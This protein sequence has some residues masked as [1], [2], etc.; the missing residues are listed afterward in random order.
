MGLRVRG[1]QLAVT[2]ESEASANSTT[3]PEDTTL[4][5]APWAIKPEGK[6]R[7]KVIF[8]CLSL[9]HVIVI[10]I[11]FAGTVIADSRPGEA[12]SASYG[13]ASLRSSGATDPL[14]FAISLVVVCVGCFA[15][16]RE[17]EKVLAAFL[18]AYGI[19]FILRL[20]NMQNFFW[21][22]PQFLS[23]LMSYS[24]SSKLSLAWFSL[25]EK[26]R[27]VELVSSDYHFAFHTFLIHSFDRTRHCRAV[28][29]LAFAWRS[30]PRCL[31]QNL[32]VHCRR[33]T[34]V[35]RKEQSILCFTPTKF[36]NCVS[37]NSKS[38]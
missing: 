6:R 19:D 30:F 11:D 28:S 38:S 4:V 5:R 20:A 16:I 26:C 12:L 23:L 2:D 22:L 8:L 34:R 9:I 18:I 15:A 31:E 3:L 13:T 27:L 35:L 1:N 21:L 29:C 7:T 33:A 25:E 14:A 32:N 36:I 10:C 37:A 17:H 24:L